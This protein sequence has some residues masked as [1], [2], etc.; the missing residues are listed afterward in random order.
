MHNLRSLVYKVINAFL[1]WYFC[2]LVY[3][4]TDNSDVNN[5]WDYRDRISHHVI[6]R[7]RL[8]F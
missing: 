2:Y 1:G 7:C 5:A 3:G 6:E 4:N 8:L